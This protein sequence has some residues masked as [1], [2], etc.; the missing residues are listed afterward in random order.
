MFGFARPADNHNQERVM[1]LTIPVWAFVLALSALVW[2][3]Y[4]LRKPSAG[5]WGDVGGGI[6]FMFSVV[7]F[8]GIWI[9]YGAFLL[10]AVSQS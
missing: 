3:P 1:T 2:V 9:A 10:G 7:V 6:W 4:L 5:Y 8:A